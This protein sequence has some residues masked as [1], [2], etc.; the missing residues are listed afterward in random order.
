MEIDEQT[1][2]PKGAARVVFSN[3][4]S[5]IKAIGTRRITTMTNGY[6]RVIEL[7]PYVCDNMRCEECLVAEARFFCPQIRCLKYFCEMCWPMS[8]MQPGLGA[9]IPMDKNN[10]H[11]HTPKKHMQRVD[12]AYPSWIPLTPCSSLSS[13]LKLSPTLSDLKLDELKIFDALCPT[14]PNKINM[15]LH[16]PKKFVSRGDKAF[17]GRIPLTP[18]SNMASPLKLIPSV[19]E[20][21]PFKPEI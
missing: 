18:N 11:L 12:K 6:E 13:P 4:A 9:H 19:F 7:K 5:Y 16:T 3:P 20:F 8:H 21:G 17:S 15:Q 14:S 10:L 1:D 2:Y